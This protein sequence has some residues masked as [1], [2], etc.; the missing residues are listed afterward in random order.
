MMSCLNQEH[1]IKPD[2]TNCTLCRRDLD[3]K[4]KDEF[5]AINEKLAILDKK[6]EEFVGTIFILEKEIEKISIA[7]NNH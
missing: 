4:I 5:K 2:L 6:K 7:L 3:D 1:L